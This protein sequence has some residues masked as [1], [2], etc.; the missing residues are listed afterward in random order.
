MEYSEGTEHCS[1]WIRP[2]PK[3]KENDFLDI[4]SINLE[5]SEITVYI[6]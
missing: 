5:D 2:P 4:S 1:Y 3:M 6:I